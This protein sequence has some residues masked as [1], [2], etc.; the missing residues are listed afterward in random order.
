M[1]SELTLPQ[2]YGAD[3]ATVASYITQ[4]R[5]ALQGTALSGA[6]IGHVDTW[7]VSTRC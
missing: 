2:G 3:P 4:V 1:M 7:T 5:S 6:G